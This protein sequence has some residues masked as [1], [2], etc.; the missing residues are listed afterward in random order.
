VSDWWIDVTF[1]PAALDWLAAAPCCLSEYT[2]HVPKLRLALFSQQ[3]FGVVISASGLVAIN[4]AL[5]HL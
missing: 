2:N 4:T 3:S 1:L 5:R